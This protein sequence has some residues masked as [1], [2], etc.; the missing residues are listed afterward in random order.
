MHVFRK[1][2]TPEIRA[3]RNNVRKHFK[4]QGREL[5]WRK[6][7]D[8]Y[9]ILVSEVMLQQ[10]QVERVV[11]KYAEFLK[12]FPAVQEL[13]EASLGEVL[14]VWSGLGDNG[15]AKMLWECAKEIVEKQ[16][17]VF[18]K[19]CEDL[20]RLRG[21]GPY[22]AGAVSAFAYNQSVV[23]IETNIRAVY[24]HH[25]F[26]DKKDITDAQLLPLIAV[27]LDIKNPRLWYNM[28]MDYGSWIKTTYGNPNKKSKHHVRQK[29]FKGSNR[30]V[31]GAVLRALAQKPQGVAALSADIKKNT[32][33]IQIQLNALKKEGLV[34]K[35]RGCWR[36]P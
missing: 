21:V 30:E 15:R 9:K 11:P 16:R 26:K 22:T 12:K 7:T 27:T 25:F 1:L 8:P 35:S 5:P 18:P 33:I 28:L 17:G 3:F 19:T 4:K 32:D 6:T 36:L 29:P 10:T 13:A 14:R 23:M 20:K 24:I 31:R 34:V 2:T